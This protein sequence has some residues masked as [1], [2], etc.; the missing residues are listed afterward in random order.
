MEWTRLQNLIKTEIL[1]LDVGSFAVKAVRLNKNESGYSVTAA[2]I[3]EIAASE[4]DS[5]HLNTVSAIRECCGLAGGK[6]K[7]AVCGLSGPEV[8]VRDFEFPS[9]SAAEIDGAVLFE[10]SQVC[11]FNAAESVVD[12]HLISNDDDKTSGILVA[13]MN[14]LVT[15]KVNLAKEA[16]LKCVL[17][18]VEGLA[19]LNCYTNLA[20]NS[21]ES[22]I[23]ILNVGGSH[24]TLVI[25]GDNGRPFVRDM[26]FAGNDIIKL[27][28]ADKGMST[29][30]VRSNLS[31][32]SKITKTELNESLGKAC[33]QLIVDVSNT[34]RY[35]A[36]QEQST[37]VE[38][39]YVCGGFALASGF[40]ELLN[41][42][43]GIEA[44]LWNPFEKIRCDTDS[45]FRDICA[46][47]GPA[48]A[49]A[50]GLA[51]RSV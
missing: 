37:R 26:T 5:N 34:L 16:A 23:A 14:T 43:F 50:A 41:N 33:K 32:E 44:V 39:I 20:E 3:T 7:L 15:D 35:Y 12:Y 36:T 27:I 4:E 49:V 24:T 17:M 22:T 28:A 45:Q 48:L 29:N 42:K 25:M 21:D 51:M 1:G 40:I 13:A 47:K 11:P 18:D 30:D 2:G 8:A 6:T 46:K 31:G 38:K 9:L 10:A 19:L